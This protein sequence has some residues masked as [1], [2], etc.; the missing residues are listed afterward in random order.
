MQKVLPALIA[1][2]LIVIIIIV[3]MATGLFESFSYSSEKADLYNYYH[4]STDDYAAVI[5]NGAVTDQQ[6]K[7]VN[8]CCYLDIDTVKSSMN[9]RFYY[10]VNGN[11]LLYTTASSVISAAVGES[12]YTVEGAATQ[13]PYVIC[14]TE[15]DKLF[16]ALDYVKLYTSLSYQLYGGNGEPYRT[17]LLTE[18]KTVTYANLS[19]NQSIRTDMD[20]KSEILS[21]LDEGSTVAVLEQADGWSK[22]QSQD[23][24][25]GYLESKYLTGSREDSVAVETVMEPE[26][27]S[28]SKSYPI[29]LAWDMVTNADANALLS[30]KLP[31]TSNLTTISP[32]WFSLADNNGTVSSIASQSYVDTAHAAGLEVWG[33]IDNMTYKEVSTYDV[34]SYSDKR[35]FVI[36]QLM[37]YA[38]QYG[39]EGIN[40]DFESLS[41]D[42]GEP[43][44]QFVRELSIQ[45]RKEGIVLSVDNYVPE[46]YTDH[47]NR[48]EQGIFADYVIIMGYDE[49]YNGSKESGSVASLNYVTNG[50]EKTLQEVPAQKVIN[51]LPLYTRIWIETPKTEEEIAAEDT[52]TEY[53]PYKLDVQTVGMASAQTAVNEAGATAAWDDVTAQNYAEWTKNGATYKVWLEDEMSLSAKLQVMKNNNL[54]GAAVWQL[55]YADS[56][57]WNAISQYY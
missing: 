48:K 38:K 13:T 22:V 12:A 6:L 5:E 9:D 27:T 50:I 57:A 24:I 43:F 41:A 56:S 51:A 11:A 31:S 52:N 16:V 45:C 10:D 26:I 36:E 39:L 40:V 23:L 44:I 1:I 20:K 21:E 25:I 19:K 28:I 42:A 46:A 47:Y 30:E 3:A 15:G 34:L 54:A 55:G 2:I 29:V 35:A 17:E 4:V 53:V 49:H 32:T 7:V 18:G 33:L 8:G 37:T 14:M